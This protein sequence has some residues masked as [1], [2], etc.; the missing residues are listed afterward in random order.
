MAQGQ[1]PDRLFITC[2]DSRL[3][4]SEITRTGVGELF[5]I[6]NAGNI[7]PPFDTRPEGVSATLEYAVAALNVPTIVVCG[8]TQCGA[9]KAALDPTGLDVVPNVANWLKF[10]EPARLAVEAAYPFFREDGKWLKLVEQNVL[11]QI[12]N[13]KTHPWV[14][15]RLAIGT[16]KLEGWVFDLYSGELRKLD[17]P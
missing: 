8:H 14:A 13:L 15:G 6:R 2:S 1:A 16:L 17:L 5:V 12:A 7:V 9:M 4:P 10:V 11:Q 3:I